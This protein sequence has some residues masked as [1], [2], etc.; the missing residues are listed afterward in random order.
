MKN[1]TIA[2]GFLALYV[3]GPGT[4]SVDARAGSLVTA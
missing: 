2:G 1:M 4:L 3:S